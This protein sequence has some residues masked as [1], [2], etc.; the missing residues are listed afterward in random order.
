[1]RSRDEFRSRELTLKTYSRYNMAKIQKTDRSESKKSYKLIVNTIKQQKIFKKIS[2][3]WS[4]M[5]L[6]IM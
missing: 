2:G 5:L 6:V 3:I 1:M 4:K